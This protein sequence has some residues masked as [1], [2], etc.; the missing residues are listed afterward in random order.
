MR[1]TRFIFT[2]LF[3]FAI[4]VGVMFYT[5]VVTPGNWPIL[6]FIFLLFVWVVYFGG[7]LI[8]NR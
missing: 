1:Q 7:Q 5:E 8:K 4:L 3:V 2:L 6:F